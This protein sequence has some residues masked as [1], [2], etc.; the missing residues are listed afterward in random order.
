MLRLLSSRWSFPMPAT[1]LV[2]IAIGVA[3]GTQVHAQAIL[4][5]PLEAPDSARAVAGGRISPDGRRYAYQVIEGKKRSLW[6][7]ELPERRARR[8]LVAA[9]TFSEFAW[10]PDGAQI[11]F[12][13]TGDRDGAFASVGEL[14]VFDIAA[15]RLVRL[16]TLPTR[17][18]FEPSMITWL[19]DR[20]IVTGYAERNLM[21]GG[22]WDTAFAFRS[23]GE[24]AEMPPG[25]TSWLLGGGLSRAGRLAYFGACCGGSKG[26]IQLVEP[27]GDHCVA[28]PTPPTEREL[29]WDESRQRLYLLSTEWRSNGIGTLYAM[30]S[31]WRGARKVLLPPRRLWYS[32]M[33]SSGDFWF[34]VESVTSE[35]VTLW[36]LRSDTLAKYTSAVDTLP[37][38][39]PIQPAIE[40]MARTVFGE[41][42]IIDEVHREPARRLT[43]F[44]A[45]I[46]APSHYQSGWDRIGLVYGDR[47][48]WM[49]AVQRPDWAGAR[50][51]SAAVG[52]LFPLRSTDEYLFSETLDSALGANPYLQFQWHAV[53]AGSPATPPDVVLRI[54]RKDAGRYTPVV[55]ANPR[56]AG[57]SLP[58]DLR[59]GFAEVNQEL[60]LAAIALP[61]VR[62]DPERL[63]RIAAL[64]RYRS[65]ERVLSVTHARLRD[66]RV[67]LAAKASRLSQGAAIQSYFACA[68]AGADGCPE[69]LEALIARRSL[70]VNR[71]VLALAATCRTE[72]PD[73]AAV[74]KALK[75]LGASVDEVLI[76]SLK[77][78]QRGEL[79]QSLPFLMLNCG[80]GTL[81]WRILDAMSRLDERFSVVRDAS[82]IALASDESTP[83]SVRV[84]LARDLAVRRNYALAGALVES[85]KHRRDSTTLLEISQLDTTRY[86][87]PVRDARRALRTFAGINDPP[88]RPPR[89]PGP[90]NPSWPSVQP[91]RPQRPPSPTRTV[92][93][94]VDDWSGALS[95][96]IV[97]FD[98]LVAS[99]SICWR[100][101]TALDSAFTLGDDWSANYLFS[102]GGRFFA[103]R[104]PIRPDVDVT[105]VEFDSAFVERGRRLVHIP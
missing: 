56:I 41:H 71:V 6:I 100:A 17:G 66:L 94:G 8:I 48:G 37:S 18:W 26:S 38:C 89:P 25:H 102:G 93:L 78:V 46:P 45:S 23:S 90:P 28:G 35:P 20:R 7:L 87:G 98:S 77:R 33:S 83:D 15:K 79:P 65:N 32:S 13:R 34:V 2:L 70:R 96:A 86:L 92:C 105:L 50:D 72:S 55:L 53:L 101:T 39:P 51:S 75:T 103:A 84:L 47:I 42:V 27:T 74:R 73:P 12:W 88:H 63:A 9:E 29:R 104:R 68:G 5:G 4:V 43:I 85:S 67:E 19:D 62:L 69:T 14:S 80:S 82:L 59:L 40:A 52:P 49:S 44:T 11:A 99:D 54:L 16:D 22:H 30:D 36:V 64:P 24:R 3:V 76:L 21:D 57:D 60:A 95:R 1:R 91:S 10:S 81:H 31:T 97:G 61:S 58:F